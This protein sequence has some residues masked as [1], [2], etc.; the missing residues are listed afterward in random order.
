MG[1]KSEIKKLIIKKL[2]KNIQKAHDMYKITKN[3]KKHIKHKIAEKI[4]RKLF[5]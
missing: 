3:P 1:I 2:P 5:K 4:I